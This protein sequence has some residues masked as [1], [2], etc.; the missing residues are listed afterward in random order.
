MKENRKKSMYFMCQN[1]AFYGEYENEKKTGQ[2]MW[3]SP[4]EIGTPDFW[5]NSRPNLIFE[6]E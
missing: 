2:K 4:T 1:S 5:T 3:P 6:G